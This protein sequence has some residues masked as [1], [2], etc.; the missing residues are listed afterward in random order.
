MN[1]LIRSTGATSGNKRRIKRLR[2]INVVQG[3]NGEIRE[4]IDEE[5]LDAI[6]ENQQESP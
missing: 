3:E 2:S 5:D 4:G 6:D 1:R